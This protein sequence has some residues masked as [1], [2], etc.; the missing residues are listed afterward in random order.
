MVTT[1]TSADQ[2]T[3][4]DGQSAAP[5]RMTYDEWRDWYDKEA[6]RRGEW[7]DGEVVVFMAVTDRHNRIVT[8]LITVLNI[9]LS[10]RRAG[11]LFS[12]E[13]E[14]RTREGAAREPDIFV[15]L[16]E[17]LDRLESLRVR[18]AA[19]LVIEIISPDSLTRDRRDKLA[20]Y[21]TVGV[22]E[23]WLVD[24]REGRETIE[25]LTLDPDGYYVPVPPDA[26]GRLH[27][28]VLPGVWAD[29]AWL[30]YGDELPD[31]VTLGLEMVAAADAARA[32]ESAEA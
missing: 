20:E 27:S 32:T 7:V 23:Y 22:P 31:V 9:Y 18:G 15:V 6:G 25:V 21:A 28:L 10:R 26:A 11:E 12:Q 16:R 5:L 29:A 8:F 2:D 3:R 30:A 24:P 1:T 17:H 14:L 4:A 13:F 19:D